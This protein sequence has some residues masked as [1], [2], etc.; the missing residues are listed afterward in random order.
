LSYKCKALEFIKVNR[1]NRSENNYE[2][3]GV[4]ETI[5]KILEENPNKEFVD[6]KHIDDETVVILRG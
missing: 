4:A 2:Y 3:N 1:H 5:N 6:V